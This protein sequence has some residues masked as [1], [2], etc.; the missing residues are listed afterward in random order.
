MPED[1][2]MSGPGSREPSKVRSTGGSKVQPRGQSEITKERF[3]ETR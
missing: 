3:S 1:E 2:I